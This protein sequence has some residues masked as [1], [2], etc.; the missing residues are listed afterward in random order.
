MQLI[1]EQICAGGDRN[2]GYLLGDRDTGQGVL[3][4][5]RSNVSGRR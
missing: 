2:L 1:F 4:S 5:S 3:I